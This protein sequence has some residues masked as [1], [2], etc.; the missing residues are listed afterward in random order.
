MYHTN[1]KYVSFTNKS[2]HCAVE[3][4]C[5]WE[6]GASR[7]GML[8]IRVGQEGG[9]QVGREGKGDER[10]EEQQNKEN[11][12]SVEEHKRN[13]SESCMF[14]LC[15]DT[16]LAFICIFNHFMNTFTNTERSREEI[17]KK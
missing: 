3:K 13:G 5:A 10:M 11:K 1:G 6:R 7:D 17:N 16:R 15:L 12:N 9:R 2:E 14:S 4:E 8:G